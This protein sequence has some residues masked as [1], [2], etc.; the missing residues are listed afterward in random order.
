MKI[1][2]AASEA[3][4]L[5]KT[6]GLADVA[7]GLPAALTG[8]GCDVRIILPAYPRVLDRAAGKGNCMALGDPLGTGETRLL[9]A[10]MPD[11]G[12]PLLLVDCPALFDRPGGPYVDAKG[13]VWPDNHLRF[14]LLSMAAAWVCKH[15]VDGWRPAVVHANDWH[16]G[17]IPAYLKRLQGPQIPSVFTIHNIHY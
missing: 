5:V 13:H 15:G 11:S 6:G 4:P 10:R 7:A 3:F 14:A 1:L 8:L 16:T 2:Y 17:L 9:A 12:V